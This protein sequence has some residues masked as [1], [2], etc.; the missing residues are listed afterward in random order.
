MSLGK[1]DIR[2]RLKIS[3]LFMNFAKKIRWKNEKKFLFFYSLDKN[4]YDKVIP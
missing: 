2:V 4:Y 3:K 1:T